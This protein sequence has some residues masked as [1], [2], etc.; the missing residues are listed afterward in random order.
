MSFDLNP[1]N[2]RR[3]RG[4]RT[5]NGLIVPTDAAALQTTSRSEHNEVLAAINQS[6]A[7]RSFSPGEAFALQRAVIGTPEA[8]NFIYGEHLS[9]TW[10]VRKRMDCLEI[11]VFSGEDNW[12]GLDSKGTYFLQGVV[13][14]M[15]LN[16]CHYRYSIPDDFLAAAGNP[17]ALYASIGTWPVVRRGGVE[18]RLMIQARAGIVPG[19]KS[20]WV[21]TEE[22]FARLGS[23]FVNA[24]PVI[25]ISRG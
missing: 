14:D 15:N 24:I 5:L 7:V 23:D 20:R 6:V 2:L 17:R 3:F 19:I 22:S 12:S 4:F 11:Q 21:S 10:E 16:V 18:E 13:A 8:Y 1:R 25:D 9:D